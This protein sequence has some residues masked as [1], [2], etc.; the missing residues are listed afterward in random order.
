MQTNPC[1]RLIAALGRIYATY[2][3]LAWGDYRE[4]HLTTG[5]YAFARGGLIAAVNNAEQAAEITVA[6]S[7][8]EYVGLLGGQ[9]VQVRDGQLRLCLQANE[10]EIFAPADARYQAYLE[11][12]GGR[13]SEPLRASFAQQTVKE[14]P[15][16]GVRAA[17]Q[18]PE[19]PYEH[20]SVEQLQAVILAKMEKNGNVTGRMRRDVAEN[21]WHDSLV[22]W[23]K[24]F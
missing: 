1:T 23:A 3:E 6:A 20:M 5:Q 18:I 19:L 14:D 17:V 21:V 24:S 16:P 8:E 4:L 13:E 9:R 10:G 12:T 15:S 2:G 11:G 7:G 22:N